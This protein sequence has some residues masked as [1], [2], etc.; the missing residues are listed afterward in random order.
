MSGGR[1]GVEEPIQ[2][3]CVLVFLF[4]V[5]PVEAFEGFIV[6]SLDPDPPFCFCRS[7]SGYPFQSGSREGPEHLEE[8]AGAAESRAKEA[9]VSSAGRGCLKGRQARGQHR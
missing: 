3:T 9:G 5:T 1:G 2:H 8:P 4:T 6:F 7:I